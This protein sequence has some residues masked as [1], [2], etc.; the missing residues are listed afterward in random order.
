MVWEHDI[1]ICITPKEFPRVFEKA[2]ASRAGYFV[3]KSIHYGKGHWYTV[4]I[5]I[6]MAKLGLRATEKRKEST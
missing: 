2:L 5:P 4:Y 1:D 6:D 3:P